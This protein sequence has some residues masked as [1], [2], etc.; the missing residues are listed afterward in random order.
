ML[1]R[2]V[3]DLLAR[4]PVLKK[5][6]KKLAVAVHQVVLDQGEDGREIAD[7]LH[8]TWLGHPLHPVLTD[9]V[10]GA[11]SLGSLFDLVAA[12]GG[13]E[14][15]EKSADTLTA[16]GTVAAIPTAISGLTD[17]STIPNP[18]ADVGL[19]HALANSVALTLYAISLKKRR[20]GERN[21]GVLYSTAGLAVATMG[22]WL[23]GHL[24]YSKKVGVDHSEAASEPTSWTPVM[25]EQDLLHHKP[26]RVEVK[27][28]PVLLYRH[29]GVVHA[30]GAVCPHAGGPLEEGKVEGTYVQ[31][32]WHDSVFDLSDGCVVH[33]PS[34]YPVT[35]YEGRIRDGRV[36]VR[37]AGQ[38]EKGHAHQH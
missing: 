33:G 16:V 31:C 34:T 8:G 13:S 26:A 7:L 30:V 19:L 14:H 9:V 17:Y 1:N 24:V 28:N 38:R 32:P 22:A 27:G 10:V 4:V 21:K 23:G 2:K 11:W 5:T 12:V 35:N 18:A 15:V 3:E 20:G 37:L 29:D 25:N 6:G 36:E